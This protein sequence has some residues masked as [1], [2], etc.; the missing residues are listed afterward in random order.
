MLLGL[1][2]KAVTATKAK[3]ARAVG[4]LKERTRPGKERVVLGTAKDLVR[5][6][7]ELVAEN[8]LVH[9][10]LIV[11]KRSVEKPRFGKSDQLIMVALSRVKRTTG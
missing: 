2:K 10:Q 4:W 6:K 8:A 3:A 7:R 9:Q 5:S 11:L 1:I